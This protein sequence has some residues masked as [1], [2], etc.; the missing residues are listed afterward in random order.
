MSLAPPLPIK[1]RREF[2]MQ[3]HDGSVVRGVDM[4]YHGTLPV[5]YGAH[6]CENV[7]Y[8]GCHDNETVFDQVCVG[9]Q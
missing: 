1:I 4:R 3:I 2:R 6:P 5:A 9:S 8:N 7:V